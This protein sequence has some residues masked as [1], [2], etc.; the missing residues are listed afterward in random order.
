VPIHLPS[1]RKQ[2]IGVVLVKQLILNDPADE[3]PLS[4]LKIRRLPRVTSDTPLFDMLHIFEEGGSH[5]ALVME[6]MVEEDRFSE[7]G[8]GLSESVGLLMPESP[9]S[10]LADR[11]QFPS[12]SS[13]LPCVSYVPLG[14]VTLEDVIEELLGQ[15]VSPHFKT[16]CLFLNNSY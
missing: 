13:A 9:S 14:I 6:R 15:E 1:D 12:S 5:M 11:Q 7:S 2:I 8:G 10:P 3:T 16:S 4:S